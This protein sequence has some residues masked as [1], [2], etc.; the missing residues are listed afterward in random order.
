MVIGLPRDG[1]YPTDPHSIVSR[2]MGHLSQKGGLV[3]GPVYRS[4]FQSLLWVNLRE[5]DEYAVWNTGRA[6]YHDDWGDYSTNEPIM[7]GTAALVYMLAALGAPD[8]GTE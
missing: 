7:G 4:I 3:D 1:D 8:G 5:Q 6:V 2:E